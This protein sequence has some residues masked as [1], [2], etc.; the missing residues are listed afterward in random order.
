[1]RNTRPD[2]TPAGM[3]IFTTPSSVGT[4]TT[5]P[6]AACEK[7]TG[8]SHQTSKPSRRKIG[9]STTRTMTCR[10]P[11]AA[12]LLPVSPSPRIILTAPSLVPGG[13]T[14][15]KFLAASGGPL[16]S[17]GACTTIDFLQPSAASW[18]VTSSV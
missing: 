5:A 17:L 1:M 10:S 4:S 7:L 16:G 12:P 3:R 11:A 6:S 15:S 18:N 2:W 9:C 13:I 14:T 8:T